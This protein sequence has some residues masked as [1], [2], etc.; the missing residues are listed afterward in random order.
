MVWVPK[1][2]LARA[3]EKPFLCHGE[4]GRKKRQEDFRVV[5]RAKTQRHNDNEDDDDDDDDDGDY[6]NNNHNSPKLP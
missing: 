1:S 4:I 2:G 6:I 3:H 5:S